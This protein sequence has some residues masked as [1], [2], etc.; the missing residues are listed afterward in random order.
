MAHTVLNRT[1]KT[2]QN[3]ILDQKCKAGDTL[4]S[5]KNHLSIFYLDMQTSGDV[6]MINEADGH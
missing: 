5:S 2:K 6:S 4:L 3:K 1:I